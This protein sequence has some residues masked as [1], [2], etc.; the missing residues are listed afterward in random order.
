MYKAYTQYE[1][2]SLGPVTKPKDGTQTVW[3]DNGNYYSLVF[4]NLNTGSSR[5]LRDVPKVKATY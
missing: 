4:L 1:G 2:F 3:V 5:F